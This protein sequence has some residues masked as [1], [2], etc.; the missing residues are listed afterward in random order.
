[1]GLRRNKLVEQEDKTRDPCSARCPVLQFA[2]RNIRSLAA[3][4]SSI[5]HALEKDEEVTT[6]NGSLAVI[7]RRFRRGRESAHLYG[8]E[9]K[10]RDRLPR[11]VRVRVSP[12]WSRSHLIGATQEHAALLVHPASVAV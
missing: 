11:R 12:S 10:R 9:A 8:L 2:I 5:I 6:P 4:Q 7:R 3:N 1:M